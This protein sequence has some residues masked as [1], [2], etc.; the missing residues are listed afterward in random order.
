M[1]Q[2]EKL[3]SK[4]QQRLEELK[5][6]DKGG[7]WLKGL[8]EW[9]VQELLEHRFSEFVGAAPH[10]RTSERKGYRNGYRARQLHTRVG[11]LHLRVPRDREG[12]FCPEI[13]ERYQ[14]SEKALVLCLQEMYLQGVSTRKV[15]QITEQLCG[16]AFSKDQVS[17]CTKQLDEPLEGWRK[18]PLEGEYP[19]LMVD[20]KY[21]HVREA[22]QVRSNSALI[23]KGVRGDGQREILAVEVANTESQTTWSEVFAA[24]KQRGLTGVKYVVSDE[25]GGLVAAL[26]RYFQGVAWQ[27]CQSHYLRNACAKVAAKQRPV[28]RAELLDAWASP[29]KAGA[30][31]RLQR[32]IERYRAGHP[33]LADWLE[34]TVESTL[35]VFELPQEH[36]KRMK[37]TNG[38]ERFNQELERRTRVVRIFPNRASYL[39]L[40]SALAMEQSEEWL[41]GHCYLDMSGSEQEPVGEGVAFTHSS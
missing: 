26:E 31:E 18:R 4:L 19:Y 25:H 9:L 6:E 37:S 28:L 39:R 38:L 24:L 1:S 22:G 2:P 3:Q 40:V 30:Q 36:R 15:R 27:R 7:D 33:E 34:E 5:I 12:Q 11:T 23:V 10:E 8:V 14:R 32:L 29:D 35:T 16:T 21:E 41:T 13:F 20:A 17:A